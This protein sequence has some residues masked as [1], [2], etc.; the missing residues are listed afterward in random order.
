MM[1][2]LFALSSFVAVSYATN[3]CEQLCQ[4]DGPEICT[5]GSWP[6]GA[7]VCHAYFIQPDGQRCYHNSI[8]RSTC[9][10]TFPA[11]TIEAAASI[12]GA[13]GTTEPL[14]DDETEWPSIADSLSRFFA[15]GAPRDDDLIFTTGEP[16]DGYSYA[17][18]GA[19]RDDDL[20]FTTGEP[21]DGYSYAYSSENSGPDFPP[22]PYVD[23]CG[24]VCQLY[25]AARRGDGED[26][27]ENGGTSDCYYNSEIHDHVC[28]NLYWSVDAHGTRGLIFETNP[29]N[30]TSVDRPL[31]CV[32][33]DQLINDDI[34][35]NDN[36]YIPPELPTNNLNMGLHMFVNSAPV[37]RRLAVE[38]VDDDASGLW[39]LLRQFANNNSNVSSQVFEI[40]N[41]LEFDF[42]GGV[43]TQLAHF[44]NMEDSFATRL[45]RGV[46]CRDCLLP[47]S[48]DFIGPIPVS[49]WSLNGTTVGLVQLLNALLTGQAATGTYVHCPHCQIPNIVV[50]NNLTFVS[51]PEILTFAM[52]RSQG[53]ISLPLLLNLTDIIGNNSL[54][55]P[56]YRLYG[57]ATNHHAAT[58]R[59]NDEW[60]ASNNGASLI[61]ITPVITESSIVSDSV[62][63]VLYE[64]V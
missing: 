31:T 63:L 13:E 60:F 39:N 28:R 57:F 27:C 25:S 36:D 6:R 17:Y 35:Q 29:A 32:S 37:R 14:S 16:H 52:M 18:S 3:P 8:T 24:S 10:D 15:T 43:F 34:L 21:H 64:R 55:N 11:L 54:P 2:T 41:D 9:R 42:V 4:L 5:G 30:L 58:I 47:V 7:G 56:I 22:S 62:S 49:Y 20:I 46:N 59:I 12:V 51:A 40:L 44:T 1:R 48:S 61:P 45:T 33:A 23:E 50:G 38:A 19:P 26:L 53:N